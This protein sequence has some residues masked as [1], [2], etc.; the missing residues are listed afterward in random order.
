MEKPTLEPAI[1]LELGYPKNDFSNSLNQINPAEITFE[2]LNY[3]VQINKKKK[4]RKNSE[5]SSLPSELT[6]IDSL[7]GSFRPGKLTAILGPSGSGKTSLLNLLSGRISSGKVT[8]NVWLNGRPAE[9]G[10]LSLV[11]R[12]ISQD[13]VMLSTM[14]VSEV[15]EM[16]IQFRVEGITKEDLE[17][18]KKYAIDILELEKCQNTRIGDPM[19]KGISGGERKRTAI[20][21]EMATNSSVLFLD[22]PTSGLDIYTSILVVKL[23]KRIAQSGQTVV[24]VIHQPSSD[25]FNLF[26]DIL[27]LSQGKAIYFGPQNNVVP[28]F[29]EIGYV[30]PTYT[31]PADFMFTDVLNESGNNFH[32]G[33]S[34]LESQKRL[35]ERLS[36]EWNKS[37]LAKTMKS[38]VQNPNISV[39]DESSFIDTVNPFSQFKLLAQRSLKNMLRNKL[40]VRI[41]IAQSIIMGLLLGIVFYNSKSKPLQ[42]QMQNYMGASFFSCIAQFLPVAINVLSTF[43]IELQ[44]IQRE[45]QSEYYSLFPYYMAKFPLQIIGPIIFSAISYFM[46]GFRGE[47]IKFVVHT[48]AM[49]LLSLNAFALG[50]FTSTLFKNI[51]VALSFLPMFL[52]IPLIFGG[53]IVNSGNMMAWIGW[54]QWVSPIKYGFTM[55]VTNMFSGYTIN[56]VPVGDTQL[57]NLDL[58]PFKIYANALFLLLIFFIMI[59]VAYFGLLRVTSNGKLGVKM[60]SKSRKKVLLGPPEERFTRITT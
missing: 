6:I 38:R 10:A 17:S 49:I 48:L 32:P 51:S 15:I 37:E 41:R 23:L 24:A 55:I 18:R 60:S 14:T 30:C 56:G 50:I 16:A 54:L 9:N 58:G 28:Y 2:N 3:S 59:I 45:R 29:S 44:V 12:F 35:S 40:L 11:S 53:F 39:I 21:M 47:S 33:M 4:G 26:D 46:V 52:V 25:I 22:E 31:N 13:D 19:D 5:K 43:S 36:D 20:A 7:S 34:K 57:S 42:V 1:D 27:L 8:G